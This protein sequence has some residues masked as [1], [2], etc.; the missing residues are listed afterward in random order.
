[1]R[2]PNANQDVEEVN[3][4]ARLVMIWKGMTTLRN[5]WVISYKIE[6]APTTQPS[7]CTLGHLAQRNGNIHSHKNLHTDVH[8]TFI[9]NT[10]PKKGK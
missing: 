9:H 5:N 10:P 4:S 2:T 8:N 1:M 6:H 7:N 3:Q